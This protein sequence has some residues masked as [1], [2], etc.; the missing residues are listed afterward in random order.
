MPSPF[1]GMDPYLET[2]ELWPLFQDAFAACLSDTLRSLPGQYD[3]RVGYRLYHSEL[4][5]RE[6]YIE[7]LRRS[8]QGLI[9]LLDVA[10]PSNKT[11]AAGRD[12]YRSRRQQAKA[13]GANH[14]EIDLV[15][16]GQPLLD[17]SRDGLPAWDYAVTVERVSHPQ[18][19]E[20]YTATLARRLPRFRLPL[21]A[22]ERDSVL[23]LNAIFERSYDQAEFGKRIDYA[24]PPAILHD[25]IAVAAYYLWQQEGCPHGRDKEH[26][27]KAVESLWR[28]SQPK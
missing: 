23:D 7:I 16:Q 20:I 8:D 12:A 15:L 22:A 25:R 13:A 18:R 6:P 9:T 27:A 1:P 28:P 19:Y 11:T 2:P 14:V 3:V 17:Y 26:W 21:E 24:N 10:T 5:H 4:E